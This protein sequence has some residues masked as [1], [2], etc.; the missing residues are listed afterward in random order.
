[1]KG[2]GSVYTYWLIGATDKAIRRVE[3]SAPIMTFF[4]RIADDGKDLRRRSPRLS[5]D[6]R[7]GERRTPSVSRYAD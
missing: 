7:T 5:I 3:K 2:K 4:Q 1:M 6:L